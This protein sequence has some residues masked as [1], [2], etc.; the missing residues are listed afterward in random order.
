MKTRAIPLELVRAAF[1]LTELL[2]PDQVAEHILGHPADHRERVF[3]RILGGRHLVQAL[4]LLAFRGRTAHGVGAS[5][6]LIH[7]ATMIGVAAIDPRR[8][9][10]ATVNSAIATVFAAGELR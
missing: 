7:A 3:I 4:V 10:A 5:V 1:G 8:K 2:L 6:D 9:V